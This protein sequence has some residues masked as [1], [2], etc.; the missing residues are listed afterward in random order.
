VILVLGG[1]GLLGS[2]IL[3]HLQQQRYP[4]RVLSRGMGDW[5]SSNL[6]KLKQMGVEIVTGD[7]KDPDVLA[8]AINGCTGVIHAGGSLHQRDANEMKAI[9]LDSVIELAR[10]SEL[11]GV[12]RFI[13][14]SCLGATQH[15]SSMLMRYKW[16]AEQVI[17]AAPFY[18]TIFRPSYFY[19]ETFPFL[20][21]V[22]PVLKL[23]P[24]IPIPGAGLNE[25]EPVAVDD[26]ANQIVQ[27]LYN[28]GSVSKLYEVGGPVTYTMI[29]FIDLIRHYMKIRT[30]TM[31]VPTDSADK[32]AK[33]FG[34]I[35][36]NVHTDLI[37][38]MTVDSRCSEDELELP[39]PLSER[40]LEESLPR[41][42]QKL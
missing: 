5:Q 3:K 18:W 23:K 16:E 20:N 30:P 6:P 33:V 10:L 19:G 24:V 40:T 35:L 26:V 21:V 41:I 32:S 13:H 17:K 8:K 14:V 12:Q 29:E 2:A 38:L 36:K 15:S 4:S 34:K 11:G 28:R 22:L 9:H 39:A 42:I 1:S 7:M 31:H 25:I 37:G 27:S